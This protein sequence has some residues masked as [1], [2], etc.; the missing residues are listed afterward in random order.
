MAPRCRQSLMLKEL[1]ELAQGTAASDAETSSHRTPL[2]HMMIREQCSAHSLF[3]HH[4]SLYRDGE[5]DLPWRPDLFHP[6]GVAPPGSIGVRDQARGGL[7]AHHDVIS[8]L[9]APGD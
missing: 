1:R 9:I 2:R 7:G 6:Q 4:Y 3:P 8:V 5:E